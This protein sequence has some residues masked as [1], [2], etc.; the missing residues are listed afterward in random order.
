MCGYFEIPHSPIAD[1]QRSRGSVKNMSR[2]PEGSPIL[3]G[4]S[5]QTPDSSTLRWVTPWFRIYKSDT[6]SSSRFNRELESATIGKIAQ[7]THDKEHHSRRRYLLI[8]SRR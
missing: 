2:N 4:I 3:A 6:A 5:P 8:N 1:D 7:C